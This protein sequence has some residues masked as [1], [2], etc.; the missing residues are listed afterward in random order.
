MIVFF[1]CFPI[2]I[3][4][5]HLKD[6]QKSWRSREILSKKLDT[7]MHIPVLFLVLI[8]ISRVFPNQQPVVA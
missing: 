6:F 5:H 8:G 1:P 3:P 7:D 4:L 2:I